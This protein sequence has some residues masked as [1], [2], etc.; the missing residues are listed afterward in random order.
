VSAYAPLD[1]LRLRELLASRPGA[2]LP[3]VECVAEIDSTN[4]ELLRRGAS[5]PDTA[6]L[7]ADAQTAGRGRRGRAWRSPPGANLHLSIVRRLGLPPR[8]LGG[9]S[10]ALG[11]ASADA[12]HVLGQAEVGLKWPNDLQARGRKLGGL[13]I[14]LA[15]DAV[16]I[17]LGLNLRMPAA[18]GAQI[19]QPW[20]DLATLGSRASR[21]EVAAVLI[22]HW[23]VALDLYRSEGLGAFLARWDALD[24]L[25][26]RDVRLLAG[27]EVV[28]GR[29]CGI[30]AD[31]GLRVRVEHGERVFHSAD[32][33]LRAA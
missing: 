3:R 4:A 30:A 27:G 17:G 10:L 18:I 20:I 22:E 11:V 5:Q 23:L 8:A 1:E 19:D 29:A 28:Q 24:V 9:L 13:L 2:A 32:V 21:E 33:S 25:A 16:V 14:E 7:I 31:G 12:L 26:G 15:A 6:V